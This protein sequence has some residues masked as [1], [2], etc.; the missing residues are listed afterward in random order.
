MNATLPLTPLHQ[1][2]SGFCRCGFQAPVFE[3]PAWESRDAALVPPSPVAGSSLRCHCA[4]AALAICDEL[5]QL[6][7]ALTLQSLFFLLFQ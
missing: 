1:L 3:K 6:T 7:P 4:D 2:S 5:C